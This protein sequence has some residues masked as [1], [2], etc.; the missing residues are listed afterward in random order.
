MATTQHTQHMAE[1]EPDEGY[2]A[3]GKRYGIFFERDPEGRFGGPSNARLYDLIDNED[4]VRSGIRGDYNALVELGAYL[5]EKGL[6]PCRSEAVGTPQV[7]VGS[8]TDEKRME[9]PKVNNMVTQEARPVLSKTDIE[10]F[11]KVVV[12]H[13]GL[14]TSFDYNADPS[15]IKSHLGEYDR[16]DETVQVMENLNSVAEYLGLEPIGIDDARRQPEGGAGAVDAEIEIEETPR[17]ADCQRG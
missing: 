10:R 8:T 3:I 2:L 14:D 1:V 6:I 5:R 13:F 11:W 16:W 4:V 17:A 7:D 15:R 9:Q 12:P